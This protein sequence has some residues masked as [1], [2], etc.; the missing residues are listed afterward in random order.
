MKRK[1]YRYRAVPLMPHLVRPTIDLQ[2]NLAR[3]C[4]AN[5][6]RRGPAKKIF[7]IKQ[8][9]QL[10]ATNGAAPQIQRI[11]IF[12]NHPDSLH[13]VFGRGPNPS[14]DFSAPQRVSSWGLILFSILIM[15]A[16]IGIFWPLL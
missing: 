11:L 12:D 16:L 6:Q 4:S 7:V 9:S 5:G 1:S 14:V 3:S 15:V 13:L 2:P 8:V 10:P